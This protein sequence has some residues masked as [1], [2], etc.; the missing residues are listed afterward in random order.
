MWSLVFFL[1]VALKYVKHFVALFGRVPQT[2]TQVTS[3]LQLG[4]LHV[5]RTQ[6]LIYVFCTYVSTLGQGIEQWTSW[7]C[8]SAVCA[9]NTNYTRFNLEQQ[10][11]IL[12]GKQNW[13]TRSKHRS[14]QWAVVSY[15]WSQRHN[16]S[17]RIACFVADLGQWSKPTGGIRHKRMPQP[18]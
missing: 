14:E 5:S 2:P 6:K 13:V 1:C 15:G 4:S 9:R 12:W 18:V 8:A 17:V 10:V 7:L 16:G 3:S 11:S